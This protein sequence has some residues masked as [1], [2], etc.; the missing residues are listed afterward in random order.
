MRIHK[1]D[2]VCGIPILNIRN[3]FRIVRDS[4]E[5]TFF[6][7]REYFS[8]DEGKTDS[9]ILE[10]ISNGFIELWEN[11]YRLT[12]KG[13]ALCIARCVPPI[14]KEKADRIFQE[15]MQRVDEVNNDNFYLYRIRKL[16]LFGSYLNP[17]NSD[18]GDID[19]A[20]D[21][22]RKIE[23]YDTFLEANRKLV[24]EV[25]KNGKS[26]S[27]FLDEMLYSKK[28]VLLKLK[29]RNR[30]ISLHSIE[31]EILN[32]VQSKQIYP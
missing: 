13:N 1:N 8:L 25:K 27:S 17:N 11:G 4:E 32:N 26:F 3:F 24:H 19:I 10:L 7:V 22:E 29:D 9:F 21:L 30:Y 6:K 12:L 20:F 31:D 18:Y 5:F 23:N 2:I 14:N 15:F 16:L 28:L